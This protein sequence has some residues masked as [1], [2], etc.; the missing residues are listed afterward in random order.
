[1][2]VD[3]CDFQVPPAAPGWYGIV[4]G[5]AADTGRALWGMGAMN[6]YVKEHPEVLKPDA[7]NMDRLSMLILAF[8]DRWPCR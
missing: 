5:D 4:C 2:M 1:M 7:P 6:V 8:R 3:R